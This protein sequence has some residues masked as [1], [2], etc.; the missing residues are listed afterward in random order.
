MTSK[1]LFHVIFSDIGYRE[2]CEQL[3]STLSSDYANSSVLLV[4]TPRPLFAPVDALNAPLTSMRRVA[5]AL[6]TSCNDTDNESYEVIYELFRNDF[7]IVLLQNGEHVRIAHEL[8]LDE[9]RRVD[10]KCDML[11]SHESVRFSAQ[12]S[13]TQSLYA[14]IA[15]LLSTNPA[16]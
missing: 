14:E 10:D 13:L 3:F 11:R 4:V 1:K 16:Q 2:K 5:Y 8:L 9:Q 12:N 15:Q 6:S 7:E